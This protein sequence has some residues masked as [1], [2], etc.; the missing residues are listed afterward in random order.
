MIEIIHVVMK[1]S[2]VGR[3][4]SAILFTFCLDR[5]HLQFLMFSIGVLDAV[6]RGVLELRKLSIE[7]QLWEASRK[8]IDHSSLAPGANHK[9][10]DSELS[11]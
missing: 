9:H 8:E 2:Y 4:G 7:Q 11:S 5:W 1:T 10:T 6:E 3:L